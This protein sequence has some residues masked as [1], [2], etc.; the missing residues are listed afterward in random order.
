MIGNEVL[1]GIILPLPVSKELFKS[2]LLDSHLIGF[3][4]AH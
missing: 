4:E 3:N 2:H 1:E